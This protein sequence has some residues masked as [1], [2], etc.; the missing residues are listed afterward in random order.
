MTRIV[1]LMLSLGLLAGTSMPVVA[2]ETTHL[3]LYTTMGDF[4]TV[5]DD[6]NIAITGRGF[7]VDHI[8]HISAML[9][10]TGKDLGTTK[11][12]YGKAESL[13]FCSATVSRRMM[14]ADP[15]NIVFCPYIIV[16]YTLPLDPKTVYVGYRRP[17][18]VGTEASKASLKAVEDLLD[19]IVKE[20]LNI[21]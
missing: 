3:K 1:A 21:K 19:G 18:P 2:A 5:K 12:V 7:V 14:E 8:S 9:D 10:R 17:L 20:A 4:D 16:L 13:Q 11:T 15:T 6:L